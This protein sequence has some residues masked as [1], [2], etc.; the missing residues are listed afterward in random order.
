MIERPEKAHRIEAARL[1]RIRAHDAIIRNRHRAQIA[2]RVTEQLDLTTRQR[3]IIHRHSKTVR[4]IGHECLST[5]FSIGERREKVCGYS[6]IWYVSHRAK[7]PESSRL[8]TV[9]DLSYSWNC[10]H[11]KPLKGLY[12]V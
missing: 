6:H 12:F 7:I 5:R 2:R 11:S 10:C 8:T 9:S 4:T 3:R 1:I